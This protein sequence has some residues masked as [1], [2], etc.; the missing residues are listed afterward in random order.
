MLVNAVHNFLFFVLQNNLESYKVITFLD[1]SQESSRIIFQKKIISICLAV[2]EIIRCHQYYVKYFSHLFNRLPT[3]IV[4]H[5]TTLG[6]VFFFFLILGEMVELSL[7]RK[8]AAA[9]ACSRL[10]GGMGTK[11]D[12]NGLEKYSEDNEKKSKPSIEYM[13]YMC[14]V[15]ES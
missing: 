10:R 9:C 7:S 4:L 2:S 11:W 6:S 12:L 5:F 8:Y 13:N 3:L 1:R 15:H 14:G